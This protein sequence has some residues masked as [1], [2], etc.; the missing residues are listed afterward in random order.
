LVLCIDAK[1]FA[2]ELDVAKFL[3]QSTSNIGVAAQARRSPS[4]IS[5]VWRR[6][7]GATPTTSAATTVSVQRRGVEMHPVP[8]AKVFTESYA[9][10]DA[11]C[12]AKVFEKHGSSC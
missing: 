11:I 4:R 2:R 7:V 5:S 12:S 9:I 6:P 10:A 8:T 1:E 3:L